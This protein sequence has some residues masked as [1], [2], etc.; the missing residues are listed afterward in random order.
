ML[1][2]WLLL[3][4]SQNHKVNPPTHVLQKTVREL[5]ELQLKNSFSASKPNAFTRGR[6]SEKE[7]EKNTR[8]KLMKTSQNMVLLWLIGQ[9]WLVP[10][11]RR[12][13][14]AWLSVLIELDFCVNCLKAAALYHTFPECITESYQTCFVHYQET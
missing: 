4:R 5:L 11:H 2:S 13:L 12:R 1:D 3:A 7:E 6:K 8:V 9:P 10:K 14:Q